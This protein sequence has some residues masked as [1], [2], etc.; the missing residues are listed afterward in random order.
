MR[1]AGSGWLTIVAADFAA[2]GRVDDAL[3]RKATAAQVGLVTID[4]EGRVWWSD[5]TYFLHGRPRW[6]RVRTVDDLAWGV[7]DP[8]SV[9]RAYIATL[10]HTGY[11]Y[12]FTHHDAY[13]IHTGNALS[14]I[15]HRD[16]IHA[17]FTTIT[18][19]NWWSQIDAAA[20]D[21]TG[22]RANAKADPGTRERR[23]SNLNRLNE[24]TVPGYGTTDKG[25]PIPAQTH[26]VADAFWGADCAIE[27]VYVLDTRAPDRH[28]VRVYHTDTLAAEIPAAD[29]AA[30]TPE[31]WTVIQCGPNWETCGHYAGTH[32]TEVPPVSARLT[33]REWIGLDPVSLARADLVQTRTGQRIKTTVLNGHGNCIKA[34]GV[35]VYTGDWGNPIP[36]PGMTYFLPPT[37]AQVADGAT[38]TIPCIPLPIP[39]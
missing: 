11:R 25:A 20:P 6:R 21:L 18:A 32:T 2:R 35:T 13:P 39:A 36:V 14:A 15:A 7:R 33:Y 27:W 12:A 28:V 4:D 22:V 30:T 34:N 9:R 38:D 26:T 5:E 19:R 29:L 1:D 31:Q 37:K 24:T 10:D 23:K 17:A 3:V 16:G 8:G